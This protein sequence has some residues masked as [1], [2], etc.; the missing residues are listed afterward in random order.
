[1]QPDSLP[2][3]S[4][5]EPYTSLIAAG[6]KRYETRDYPPPF[7]Y[8]G[9]RI[10]L[11]AAKRRPMRK[12]FDQGT[13][14]AITEALGGFEWLIAPPR[15][16]MVVCTAV[17]KGA[18]RVNGVPNSVGI[19]PFDQMRVT[20]AS[21]IPVANGAVGIQTDP[22]GDYR[23]DRWCWDLADV[24]VLPE[25]IATRGKQ[26]WWMWKPPPEMASA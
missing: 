10:A 12:D 9:R 21:D 13:F 20:H 7:R 16:G 14:N 23:M 4:L 1:M 5:W 15:L 2:A 22:F 18:F 25:G 24:H 17:I 19:V 11:H 26:G 8:I 3:I 6:V